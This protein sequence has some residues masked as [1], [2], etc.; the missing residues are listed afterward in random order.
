MCVQSEVHWYGFLLDKNHPDSGAKLL[1]LDEDDNY[2]F[3]WKLLVS[4]EQQ[5]QAIKVGE[6]S[7][8]L[9]AH[10]VRDCNCSTIIGTKR[11]PPILMMLPVNDAS[12]DRWITFYRRRF[13]WHEF[14]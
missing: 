11:V 4:I 10:Q 6:F 2:A 7:Q 8:F 14:L 12:H 9:S 5:D 13:Y 3:L 1:G